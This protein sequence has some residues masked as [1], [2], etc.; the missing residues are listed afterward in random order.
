MK[1]VLT[2]LIAAFGFVA[3]QAQTSKEEARRIILGEPKN[4]DGNSSQRGRDII[5]GDGGNDDSRTYPSTSSR[6]ARIDQVNRDYNNKIN[7]I[8]NNPY[9]SQ[10]EK[11]RMI[12]QL[13]NDRAKKIREIN[14]SYNSKDGKKYKKHKSNNGKHKGWTKGKGNKHRDRDDD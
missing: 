3:V 1:K 11:E 9:L 10:S 6:Q 4:S 12:R 5:L 13:E 2:L 8:R 14:S 7:S